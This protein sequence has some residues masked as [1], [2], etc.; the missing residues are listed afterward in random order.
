ME[1]NRILFDD[2]MSVECILTNSILQLI[3]SSEASEASSG[4]PLTN[5]TSLPLPVLSPKETAEETSESKPVC[6]GCPVF[7]K[8]GYQCNPSIETLQTYTEEELRHVK[9][10]SIGVDGIGSI[11]W[12]EPVD[13]YGL[14]LDKLIIIEK[15]KGSSVIEV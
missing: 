7:T 5:S 9:H 14:D 10:F 11:E 12:E 8:K 13:L 6:N 1:G 2:T 4:L 15:D 3:E